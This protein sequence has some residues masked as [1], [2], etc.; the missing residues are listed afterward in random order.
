M[1]VKAQRAGWTCPRGWMRLI[2]DLN[3]YSTTGNGM[4]AAMIH[5][6]SGRGSAQSSAVQYCSSR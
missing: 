2:Q 3:R 5:P 4:H 6:Q 1:P